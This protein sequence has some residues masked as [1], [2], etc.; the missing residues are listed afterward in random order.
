MTS[1]R[2]LHTGPQKGQTLFWTEFHKQKTKKT[3]W[4]AKRWS[5]GSGPQFGNDSRWL[6]VK[7]SDGEPI[8][9]IHGFPRDLQ[10]KQSEGR[11]SNGD[12]LFGRSIFG[13]WPKN[14]LGLNR[15]AVRATALKTLGICMKSR[16]GSNGPPPRLAKNSNCYG[17][18]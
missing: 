3:V 14:T 6:L 2:E 1:P 18:P 10:N 17:F 13:H 4:K 9:A 7:S 8:Q 15:L 5:I 12:K 11:P 16:S